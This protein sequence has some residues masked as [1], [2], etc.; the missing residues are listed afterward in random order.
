MQLGEPA[1]LR[2]IEAARRP[3]HGIPRGIRPDPR[4][5]R[6]AHEGPRDE[7]QVVLPLREHAR[8]DRHDRA[9]VPPGGVVGLALAQL[10]A[11]GERLERGRLT[12]RDEVAPGGH[13]SILPETSD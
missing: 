2:R 7:L 1:N 12:P 9:G 8:G 13:A 10:D 3:P 5:S 6:S 4:V 11:E